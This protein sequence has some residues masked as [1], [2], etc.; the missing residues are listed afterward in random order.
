VCANI[1]LDFIRWEQKITAGDRM[2]WMLF[3]LGIIVMFVGVIMTIRFDDF[4]LGT[5]I[6]F[7]GAFTVVRA[8]TTRRR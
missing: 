2:R 8:M 5:V 7:I 1:T 4:W 3:F 6:A